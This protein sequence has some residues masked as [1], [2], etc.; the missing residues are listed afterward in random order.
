MRVSM[1]INIYC[2]EKFLWWGLRNSL[3]YGYNNKSLGVGLMLCPFSRMIPNR[4]SAV[5]YILPRLGFLAL[6]TESNSIRVLSCGTGLKANQKVIDYFHNVNAL[7]H[8]GHILACQ[9]LL[10]YSALKCNRPYSSAYKENSSS[11]YL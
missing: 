10:A 2:E 8:H 5:A 6:L 1:L 3:I 4:L 7:L 9:S 11:M